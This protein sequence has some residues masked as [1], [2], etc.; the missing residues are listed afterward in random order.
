MD[1]KKLFRFAAEHQASDIHLFFGQAPIL[2]I[3]GELVD[4]SAIDQSAGFSPLSALDLEG[5]LDVFLTKEQRQRFLLDRD[6]DL[7]YQI[8]NYRYRINFAFEKNNI[9]VSAR[10][11]SDKKQALTEI[12]MPPIIE[13][14]LDLPQGFILVTGPTGCGKSTTLASMINYIND[15]KSRH[16]VTLEDPIE[17]I[18]QPNKSVISQRQLGTDMNSFAGG[19]KHVDRKSVV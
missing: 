4:A 11:I 5:L 19:L 7:G 8:D 16:I 14:L 12:G 15:N 17:Y 1:I 2:R 13:K 9:M 10:V 18:F 6:L 3:D